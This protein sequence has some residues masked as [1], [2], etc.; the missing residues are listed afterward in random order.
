MKLPKECTAFIWHGWP[1]TDLHTTLDTTS[2][3]YLW[4][5]AFCLSQLFSSQV[6]FFKVYNYFQ[7][8]NWN[9]QNTHDRHKYCSKLCDC[10][11]SNWLIVSHLC[12]QKAVN[13]GTILCFC[14]LSPVAE[15]IC[16]RSLLHFNCIL[17][18]LPKKVKGK[19]QYACDSSFSLW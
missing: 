5:K 6:I 19:K 13:G 2:I 12:H 16:Q 9:K 7:A 10:T 18:S 4:N 14:S 17:K 1:G 11:I 15:A 8:Q 3:R